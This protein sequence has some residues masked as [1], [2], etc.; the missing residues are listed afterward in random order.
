MKLDLLD[1]SDAVIFHAGRRAQAIVMTKDADFVRLLEQHGPPPQVLWVTVGNAS[2]ARMKE[3]LA[4]TLLPA[5][6]L[7]RDGKPLVEIRD[8]PRLSVS[9]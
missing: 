2:N 1:A 9:G 5:L 7:L 6:D 4:E 3:V 8:R